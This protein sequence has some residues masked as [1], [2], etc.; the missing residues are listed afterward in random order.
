MTTTTNTPHT[1]STGDRARNTPG[2]TSDTGW[3]C[4]LAAGS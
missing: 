4:H 1:T 2:S 3:N